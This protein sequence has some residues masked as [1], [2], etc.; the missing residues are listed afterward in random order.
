[1]AV[2]AFI[3]IVAESGKRDR[4]PWPST[5]FSLGMGNEG[6]DAGRDGRSCLAKLNSQVRTGTGNARART[7]TYTYIY[8][9][10]RQ[11]VALVGTRQLRSQDPVSAHAHCTEGVTRFEG[12]EANGDGNGGGNGSGVGGGNGE[13][14]GGGEGAETGTGEGRGNE[15]RREWGRGWKREDERQKGTWTGEGTETRAIAGTGTGAGTGA[16]SE[17]GKGA[18]MQ[19]EG[20]EEESFGIRHTRKEAEQKTRHCHSARGTIYTIHC[21]QEVGLTGSQQL[22]AQD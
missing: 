18:G 22:L 1:M 21:R 11:G 13:G 8:I 4:S 16:G 12:E 17:T 7:H 10:Q 19:R 20:G 5:R 2:D 9:P 15:G 6:T 14:N 3:V